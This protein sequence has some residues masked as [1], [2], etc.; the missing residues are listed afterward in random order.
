MGLKATLAAAAAA[1]FTAAGDVKVKIDLIDG[2]AGTYDSATDATTFAAPTAR[3]VPAVK[4]DTTIEDGESTVNTTTYLVLSADIGSEPEEDWWVVDGGKRR[5]V[6]V[7][8]V[9]GE[10]VYILH[11]K[12]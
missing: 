12:R 4:Y 7:E 3:N 1:G 11:T 6:L 2:N 10:S 5:I 8:H 9:P